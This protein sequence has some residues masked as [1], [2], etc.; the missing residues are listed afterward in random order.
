MGPIVAIPRR[1][2]WWLDDAEKVRRSGT[3]PWLILAN[4]KVA[5]SFIRKANPEWWPMAEA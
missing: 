2:R 5:V 4:R 1:A 3:F